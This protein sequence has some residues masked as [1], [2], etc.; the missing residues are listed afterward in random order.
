MIV[1][2]QKVE[3]QK[4]GS[5][6]DFISPSD[7]F[8]HLLTPSSRAFLYLQVAAAVYS[9]P[10]TSPGVRSVDKPNM[11]WDVH[12]AKYAQSILAK[13]QAKWQ[14]L[15]IAIFAFSSAC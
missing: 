7:T 6:S 3:K 9:L 5:K 2:E 12:K 13:T 15:W 8:S 11:Q 14:V 1:S 10:Q 4:Q